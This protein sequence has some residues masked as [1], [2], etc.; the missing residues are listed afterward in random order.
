M[1]N[2][3]ELFPALK[4]WKPVGSISITKYPVSSFFRYNFN[5]IKD[6]NSI[7]N[8][9]ALPRLKKTFILLQPHEKLS[10]NNTVRLKTNCLNCRSVLAYSSGCGVCYKNVEAIKLSCYPFSSFMSLKSIEYP[11]SVEMTKSKDIVTDNVKSTNERECLTFNIRTRGYQ[12]ISYYL[13]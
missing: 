1:F 2:F 10:I 6:L 3:L 13:Y 12:D 8:M 4:E 11:V 5:I 7:I 9:Y